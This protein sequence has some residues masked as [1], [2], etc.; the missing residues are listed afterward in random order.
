MDFTASWCGPCKKMEE[1]LWSS[2]ELLAF[3]DQFTFLK[4]DVD[5]A[6][7]VATKFGM[8]GIPRVII[9]D[10]NEN[11]LWDQV[12]YPMQG[13]A[14]IAKANKLYFDTFTSMPAKMSI[15]NRASIPFLTNSETYTDEY[16]L[17]LGY[18][19]LA[20]EAESESLR[21]K[22]LEVSTKHFKKSAKSDKHEL[23]A[24]LKMIQNIA[25][26][27]NTEK[28]MKKLDKLSKPLEN[29]NRTLWDET[30]RLVELKK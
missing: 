20:I 1:S 6:R 17:A 28:A 11:I 25:L 2:S 3:R 22:F 21:Y 24:E 9:M 4:I 18:Q 10:I 19:K 27:G 14:L 23:S 12:G 16:N 8:K 7:G 15:V 30:L 13:S 26:N 29:Q 5:I